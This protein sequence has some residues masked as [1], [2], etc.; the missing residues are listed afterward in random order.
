MNLIDIAS[1]QAGLDLATMFSKNPSLGGVI[2]KMTQGTGYVNPEAAKWVD[3]L[4]KKK[5]PL[6]LYHYLDTAGAEA[7]AKH[8]VSN[9]KPYIGKAVL[10]IDYE[11]DTLRM[12]TG[13]LKACLDEVYRLTGVKPLVYCSQSVTQSQNFSAIA[14][15]GYRLW[16][17]QYASMSPVAGFTENPWH[18][19]SV[20][21]FDGFIMQQY[22][23][24]G[25]LNGWSAGLDFDKFF[26]DAAGWAALAGGSVEPAPSPSPDPEPTPGKKKVSPQVIADVLENKYGI[27]DERRRKLTSAGY[28]PDEVQAKINELYGIAGKVKPTLSGNLN[29]LDCIGKILRG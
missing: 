21:P 26:G 10:A 17:A 3:W 25:K 13:Y 1:W 16:M 5:K 29:Y 4:V 2:V 12:G 11:G 6:G 23:S 15:A 19:G 7:E 18:K 22:T 14:S 27:K 9:A 8:F 24:N 20:S 28:D